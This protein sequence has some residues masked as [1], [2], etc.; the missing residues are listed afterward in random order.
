MALRRLLSKGQKEDGTLW[1]SY[2]IALFS[3]Q[4]AMFAQRGWGG[5]RSWNA[6]IVVYG[7]FLPP[8]APYVR[9]DNLFGRAHIKCGEVAPL[10][11]GLRPVRNGF[12]LDNRA[13]SASPL[14]KAKNRKS[15]GTPTKP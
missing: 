10:D 2:F 13:R 11:C 6:M 8:C 1:T 4:N 7:A 14:S 15:L 9:A 3:V 5:D 12:L